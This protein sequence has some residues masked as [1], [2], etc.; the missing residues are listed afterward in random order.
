MNK[1]YKYICLGGLPLFVLA[2]IASN[3]C[4][5]N[6]TGELSLLLSEKEN[7]DEVSVTQS[8]ISE[9]ELI[10]SRYTDD[11]YRALSSKI[12]THSIKYLLETRHLE[13]HEILSRPLRFDNAKTAAQVIEYRSTVNSGQLVTETFWFDLTGDKPNLTEYFSVSDTTKE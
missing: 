5:Q 9:N 1:A 4:F 2:M 6:K 13:M 3:V 11:E 10:K 7:I 8:T 12:L